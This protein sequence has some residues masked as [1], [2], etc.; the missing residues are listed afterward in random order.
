MPKHNHRRSNE[1]RQRQDRQE[2][3]TGR[4]KS[5]QATRPTKNEDHYTPTVRNS[6]APKLAKGYG[7]EKE[8]VRVQL[9]GLEPSNTI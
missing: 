9:C 5:H 7:D 8:N 4:T 1:T 2:P 3:Y 6:R